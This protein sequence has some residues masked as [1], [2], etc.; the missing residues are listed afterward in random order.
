M[1]L[2]SYPQH[3]VHPDWL[4]DHLQDDTV[5]VVDCRFS[6]QA[7]EQGRQNYEAGHIPGAHYLALNQ[8]LSGPVA[9]HGG[10]HPLPDLEAV[11][12]RFESLGITSDPPTYVVAYD[13]SRFAFASRLWWLLRYL[14]HDAVA[15]LD[16]GLQGWQA[17]GYGLSTEVP[18]PASGRFSP[19]L[20]ADWLVD[21]DYVRQRQ[22]QRE[23]LLI[24]SRS[25]ARYRGEQE[26]I[27]P[28]A[29]SIPGSVN[30]FWQAVS[31]GQGQMRSQRHLQ[32]HW[33]SLRDADEVI[34]YCGSGVTACV[35]LLSQA[36]AG[37]P[38]HKLYLGG[39]SDWCS[40]LVTPPSAS[41]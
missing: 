34:V 9:I 41:A 7:P 21:I 6:L 23:T 16:G 24:D 40:Y 3:L 4:H 33:A 13:D 35:N 28:V 18:Q 8:D 25:P 26:P 15:V 17:R 14:G 31:D 12:K 1:A 32:A 38:M 11:S 20:Q 2:V 37:E 10:R 39:W 27:D 22:G 30:Y 5:V 36:I 29:G 19:R